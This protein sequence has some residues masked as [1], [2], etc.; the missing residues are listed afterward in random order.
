MKNNFIRIIIYQI[1][2]MTYFI[3]SERQDPMRTAFD[4]Q[5]YQK[6][7]GVGVAV[8]EFPHE[9]LVALARSW[10]PVEKN[11][12]VMVEGVTYQAM[13]LTRQLVQG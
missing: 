9:R 1:S 2:A 4:L 5:D 7:G 3:L 10:F 12:E 6:K 11:G 13:V 8:I